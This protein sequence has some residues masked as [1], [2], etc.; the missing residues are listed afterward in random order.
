MHGKWVSFGALKEAAMNEEFSPF[1]YQRP[2]VEKFV[3]NG[4]LVLVHPTGSGKTFTSIAA[5]ERA[6]EEG[7]A[8]KALIVV[9]TSLRE[10]F[11]S[12][13][14]K[15]TDSSVQVF[16]NEDEKRNLGYST[17]ESPKDTTYNVIGYERFRMDPVGVLNATGADTMIFDEYHRLRNDD[18]QTY[19]AA[20]SVRPYFRNFIGMTATPM[21]N[22]VSELS[23]LIALATMSKHPLSDPNYL[24]DRYSPIIGVQKGFFGGRKK[25]RGIVNLDDFRNEVGEL[26][27][28]ISPEQVQQNFPEKRVEFVDVEMSPLQKRLYQYAMGNVPPDVRRKIMEGLPVSGKEAQSI[29]KMI[30]EARAVSNS[31]GALNKYID[32]RASSR[33]TP[34]VKKLLDD[35]ESHLEEVPDAQI[36]IY[37]NDVKN[38]LNTIAAGLEDRGIDYGLFLGKGRDF[39]GHKVTEESRQGDADKFRK[40]K[41]KVLLLSSAGAAGVDL[42]NGT[43]F[44]ALEGHFNPIQVEQPEGRIRR[45]KGLS[46]RPLEDRYVIIRRYRSVIPEKRSLLSRILSLGDGGERT[47]DEWVYQTALQKKRLFTGL[48]SALAGHL[49]KGEDVKEIEVPVKSLGI[50]PANKVIRSLSEEAKVSE[51]PPPQE[52]Q[53][54]APAPKQMEAPAKARG[55]HKYISKKWDSMARRWQYRYP[56][57]LGQ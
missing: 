47:V 23:P 50:Q 37:S 2:A 33:L 27:D 12:A 52:P 10:N 45:A 3:R 21:A 6:K 14:R 46:H 15:F 26:V 29:F 38:G 4:T 24:Q 36:V 30:H 43:M 25:V 19:Q 31:V 8:G 51:P 5:M 42:P 55:P 39:R 7:K 17:T 34:K 56:E 20:Y 41:L 18:T 16:G 44:Q 53:K 9:P 48:R 40:G 35:T 54:A 49:E 1:S 28:Y 22:K 13:V 11:A 57:E 32:A